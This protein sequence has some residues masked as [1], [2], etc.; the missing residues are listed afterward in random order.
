MS[1]EV[2]KLQTQKPFQQLTF[3]PKAKVF[4]QAFSG[5]GARPM[6]RNLYYY[7]GSGSLSVSGKAF[8]SHAKIKVRPEV[9]IELKAGADGPAEVL[10]LQGRDIGEPTVQHGPFVGNTQQDVRA[11][12]V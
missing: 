7:A 6:H 11:L 3:P 9:A 5:D 12:H 2:E 4:T 8:S 10:V 1:L